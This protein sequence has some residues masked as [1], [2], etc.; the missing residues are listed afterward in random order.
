MINSEPPLWDTRSDPLER[1]PTSNFELCAPLR[2]AP[3][4]SMT[5]DL[6]Y[7]SFLPSVDPRPLGRDPS[8]HE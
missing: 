5:F 2:H 7:T 4:A 6:L 8:L 3:F 1:A